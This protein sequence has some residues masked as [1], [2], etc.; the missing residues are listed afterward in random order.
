MNTNRRPYI[1]VSR[2]F[3]G[4][5]VVL[6]TM[7]GTLMVVLNLAAGLL[8]GPFKAPGASGLVTGFTVPFFLVILNRTTRTFG[9]LTFAWVVYSTISI[10]L[11]LMGPPN[12]FKPLFGLFIALAFEFPILIF[13]RTRFSYYLG[14][15]AY[16]LAIVAMAHIAFA[17]LNL[18]GSE[19]AYKLVWW[20]ALVFF[21]EGCISIPLAQKAFKNSVQGSRLERFFNHNDR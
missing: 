8:A 17:W 16:T 14:L 18:P 4:R 10:P 6:C 2:L 7:T 13:R 15:L 12:I 11:H 3:S 5:S 1:S 20:I 21:V 9:T 19:L